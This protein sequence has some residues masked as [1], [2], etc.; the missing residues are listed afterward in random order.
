[1]KTPQSKPRIVLITDPGEIASIQ[2]GVTV[3]GTLQDIIGGQDK[4]GNWYA[5][6]FSLERYRTRHNSPT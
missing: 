1:M 2:R 6:S 5:Y 4:S 3:Q